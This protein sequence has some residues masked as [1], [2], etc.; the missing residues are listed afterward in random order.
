MG[1]LPEPTGRS[2]TGRCYRAR[3][4]V[5]RAKPGI[6]C[7]GI[8][9]GKWRRPS[10]SHSLLHLRGSKRDEGGHFGGTFWCCVGWRAR[11]LRVTAIQL[12]LRRHLKNGR[13]A[14]CSRRENPTHSGA[15]VEENGSS[16]SPGQD[17]ETATL[18]QELGLRPG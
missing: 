17:L 1:A 7:E 6:A 18:G 11:T 12:Q 15:A 14:H 3:S 13:E 10:I 9:A 5:S 8:Y 2:V 4:L 16:F